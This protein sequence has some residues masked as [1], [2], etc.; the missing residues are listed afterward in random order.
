VPWEL[1]VSINTVRNYTRSVYEKHD[2]HSNA[3]S[4]TEALPSRIMCNPPLIRDDEDETTPGASDAIRP[5]TN[6]REA[7][8]RMR[9]AGLLQR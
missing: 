6:R 4:V 1:H 3:P 9:R 5:S 7:D 2:V 8:V